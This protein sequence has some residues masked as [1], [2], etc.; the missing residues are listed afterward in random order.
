MNEYAIEAGSTFLFACSR[1]LDDTLMQ[2]LYSLEE[3]GIGRRRSE[4]FGRI[5]ISDPFHLEGEQS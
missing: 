1:E 4:G 5:C 2:A 3:E